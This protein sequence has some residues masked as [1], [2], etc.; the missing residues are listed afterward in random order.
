M[1]L[2]CYAGV[3]FSL[4]EAAVKA[5]AEPSGLDFAH[6][7]AAC[8]AWARSFASQ[9]VGSSRIASRGGR[10]PEVALL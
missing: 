7:T 2:L 8:R 10:P 6:P 4:S 9:P 3:R 5:V 1:R